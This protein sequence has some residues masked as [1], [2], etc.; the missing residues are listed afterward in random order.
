MYSML[1]N[2]MMLLDAAAAAV[3]VSE[4]M[5][6]MIGPVLMVLGGAGAI[7]M[8][9]LGVQYAKAEDDNK[10]TEVK[11]RL[12]NIGIGICAIFVLAALC[13]AVDWVGVT[14][15]LFGGIWGAYK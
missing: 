6:S 8:I 9:V 14:Q 5:H 11:K 12:L 1:G 4:I 2:M 15:D 3:K 10:R 7:Y 13:I